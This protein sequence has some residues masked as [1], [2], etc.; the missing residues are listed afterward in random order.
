MKGTLRFGSHL[1]VLIKLVELTDGPILEMGAG[2]SSTPF[3]HWACFH[4]KRTLET[5]E[6]REKYADM[7]R[8]FNTDYHK[9]IHVTDW[10]AI[11]LD[12]PW[13]IAFIDH[14]PGRRRIKDIAKLV[15][16]EYVVAHDSENAKGTEYKYH[17]ILKLFKYR[18]KYNLIRPYTSIWSN[19]NDVRGIMKMA[20][21]RVSSYDA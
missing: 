16:A 8:S 9:I 17:K 18:Y 19:K 6:N 13:S 7:F 14:S 2:Y 11:D 21:P 4:T 20:W 15:H 12:R 5:Y 3:L 1:P 10:D